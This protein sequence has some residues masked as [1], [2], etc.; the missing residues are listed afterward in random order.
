MVNTKRVIKHRNV[1]LVYLFSII[2]LGIYTI[3]WVVSTKND[4]NSV[5]GDVPTGWLLIIPIA[6]LYWI[7][8]YSVQFYFQF[9]SRH[10]MDK[11]M[12]F[13]LFL[14]LHLLLL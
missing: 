12:V 6:N 7:Y 10:H 8:N 3:Y 5:G 9:H 14:V 2:T 1:V 4:I 11:K 13:S